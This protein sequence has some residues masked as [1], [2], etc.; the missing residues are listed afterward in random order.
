MEKIWRHTYEVANI[1][2][3]VMF[4]FPFMS[5]SHKR[6]PSGPGCKLNDPNHLDLL[7]RST[8]IGTRED[9][10]EKSGKRQDVWTLDKLLG[11]RRSLCQ[12]TTC[13][14]IRV[15]TRGSQCALGE[16][17]KWQIGGIHDDVFHHFIRFK[18]TVMSNYSKSFSFSPQT[19]LPRREKSFF[20][21][22]GSL[23]WSFCSY[24]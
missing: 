20:V 8:F 13:V 21:Y 15:I 23:Y 16:V 24:A 4:V 9:G 11:K 5:P 1:F 6:D 3:C 18:K 14:K 7:H 22:W 12:D 2:L 10:K 17:D 19:F